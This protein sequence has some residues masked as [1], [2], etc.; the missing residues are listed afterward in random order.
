MEHDKQGQAPRRQTTL[1]GDAQVFLARVGKVGSGSCKVFRDLRVCPSSQSSQ[2]SGLGPGKPTEAGMRQLPGEQTSSQDRQEGGRKGSGCPLA[3]MLGTAGR[4]CRDGN[5]LGE[6]LWADKRN[7]S[8]NKALQMASAFNRNEMSRAV[9]R[10]ALL[11]KG[12][13]TLRPGWEGWSG[14][15]LPAGAS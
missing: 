5:G 9:V 15:A 4:G 6:W 11:G 2:V 13:L 3:T 14:S 8:G 12:E 10:T 7:P 1:P